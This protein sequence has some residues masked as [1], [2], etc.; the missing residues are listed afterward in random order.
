[1]ASADTR[2][3]DHLCQRVLINA[4]PAEGL[5]NTTVIIW[6]A[7]CTIVNIYAQNRKY[8]PNIS[9]LK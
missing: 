2:F 5:D 3:I 4:L 1:M 8:L 7:N 6:N 9:K